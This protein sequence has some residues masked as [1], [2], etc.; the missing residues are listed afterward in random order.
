VAA[1]PRH[2]A[3]ASLPSFV[4]VSNDLSVKVQGE[5]EFVRADS[6]ARER[7][8]NILLV[9]IIAQRVASTP[10]PQRRRRFIPHED[11]VRSC[12]EDGPTMQKKAGQRRVSHSGHRAQVR[13][14]SPVFREVWCYGDGFPRIKVDDFCV[15]ERRKGMLAQKRESD[16]EES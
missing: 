10:A 11:F 9:V 13:E 14:G 6:T 3:A 1:F 12:V 15:G 16:D 7:I 8:H 5:P 2:I 4:S